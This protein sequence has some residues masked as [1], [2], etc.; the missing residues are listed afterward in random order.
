METGHVGLS[1]KGQLVQ[2]IALAIG[3][4]NESFFDSNDVIQQAAAV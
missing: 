3:M 2:L 4:E 1:K